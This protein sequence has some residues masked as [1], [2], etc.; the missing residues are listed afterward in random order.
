MYFR[1]GQCNLELII[2]LCSNN[3]PNSV[4]TASK[5][6]LNMRTFQKTLK[7]I[8]TN[9]SS[10]FSTGFQGISRLGSAFIFLQ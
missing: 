3:Y 6:K 7:A 1:M 4:G 2:E 10:R 8:S 9:T 5:V